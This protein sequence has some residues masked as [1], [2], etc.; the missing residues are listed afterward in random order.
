MNQCWRDS[1]CSGV[2]CF[3]YLK[4]R[5]IARRK[6]DRWRRRAFPKGGNVA[7]SPG[8]IY[9]HSRGEE[10]AGDAVQVGESAVVQELRPRHRHA[11]GYPGAVVVRRALVSHTRQHVL[12]ILIFRRGTAG[13]V[14]YEKMLW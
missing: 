10:P 8:R 12:L 6:N 5:S 13:R 4:L 9:H 7:P 3:S 2:W 11:G 1:S 14:A